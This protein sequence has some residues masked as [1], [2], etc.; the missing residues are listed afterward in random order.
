MM[1]SAVSSCVQFRRASVRV[2]AICLNIFL[3]RKSSLLPCQRITAF[4]ENRLEAFLDS[5][6]TRLAKILEY[7]ISYL[8]VLSYRIFLFRDCILYQSLCLIYFRIHFLEAQTENNGFSA[9]FCRQSFRRQ[10]KFA[11]IAD[12]CFFECG[13]LHPF[14]KAGSDSLKNIG[15][16]TRRE[17]RSCII[18]ALIIRQDKVRHVFS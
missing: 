14:C 1:V 18:N 11:L 6:P 2:L 15:P 16:A 4:H 17:V 7:S 8:L 10:S 12:N 9:G 3:N 5:A 13:I